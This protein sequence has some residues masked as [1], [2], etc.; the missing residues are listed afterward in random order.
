MNYSENIRN[1][2]GGH[3]RVRVCGILKKENK[4]LL[5]NHK[6]MNDDNIFWNFPGGGVEDN[7]SLT[8]ALQR[9]FGEEVNLKITVG[10]FCF[11]NQVIAEPLHAIELYFQVFTDNFEAEIGSDPELNILSNLKWMSLGDIRNLPIGHRPAFFSN[12]NLSNDL[13]FEI[14]P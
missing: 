13:S 7:E 3:T 5:V 8:N 2:Y 10:S 9:E 11:L 1:I 4:Y 6:Q 12:L 14:Q